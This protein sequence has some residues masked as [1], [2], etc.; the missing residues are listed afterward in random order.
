MHEHVKDTLIY[1]LVLYTKLSVTFVMLSL[2]LTPSV[3]R[4]IL[5]TPTPVAN[6]VELTCVTNVMNLKSL[7]V[8]DA[9]VVV[10]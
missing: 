10:V 2:R 6:Y 1:W 9:N 8:S 7:S 4:C 5:T 3:T